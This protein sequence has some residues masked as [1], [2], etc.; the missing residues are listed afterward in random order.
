MTNRQ[1][2]S[3]Q[4]HQTAFV[5]AGGGSLGACQVGMLKALTEAGIKPG[6]LIGASVGAI[7]AAYFGGHPDTYGV[8]ELEKIWLRMTRQD[9]FPL[10]PWQGL[11][12]FIARRN[13]FVSPNALRNLIHRE[14]HYKM[15][16]DAQVPV[17]IVA[18]DVDHGS[19]VIISTGHVDTALMASTAIP[20]IFPP[21]RHGHMTLIDGGVT[22]NTPILAGVVLGAKRLV[23][24]PTG[25]PTA[26]LK[27]PKGAMPLMLHALNLMVISQLLRDVDYYKDKAEIIVIPP[28]YPISANITD[29]S[30]SKELIQS[31]Y[32]KTARWL[33][34]TAIA[35]GQVPVELAHHHHRRAVTLEA[36]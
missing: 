15:L 22:N 20:G 21:V 14:I 26:F 30:Q 7:N 23:I 10:E 6:M 27:L 4:G 25:S 5:F 16:Q 19:E 28:P 29:F 13:S 17:H 8:Q 35:P 18:T 9:I 34:H 31:S 11:L 3:Q 32:D 12:A 33:H 1:L 36:S 24:L 2:L